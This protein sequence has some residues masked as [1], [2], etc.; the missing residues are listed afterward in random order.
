MGKSLQTVMLSR[1]LSAAHKASSPGSST[2]WPR[3]CRAEAASKDCWSETSWA[4]SSPA[5]SRERHSPLRPPRPSQTHCTG[6]HPS[7][8]WMTWLH[9]TISKCSLFK[10]TQS[11]LEHHSM[12]LS[13]GGNTLLWSAFSWLTAP[14]I[15][16]S[17]ELCL[18]VLPCSRC[19]TWQRCSWK[20][21]PPAARAAGSSRQ[22][23]SGRQSRS[24]T[25]ETHSWRGEVGADQS[26]P[27]KCTTPGNRGGRGERRERARWYLKVEKRKGMRGRRRERRF[28]VLKKQQLPP[29]PNWV[30]SSSASR[31]KRQGAQCT[32]CCHFWLVHQPHSRTTWFPV[33]QSIKFAVNQFQQSTNSKTIWW[34]LWTGSY[35]FP[36]S[37][38]LNSTVQ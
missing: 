24:G 28:S 13:G 10:H 29:N 37:T 18:R 23:G 27:T 15:I 21:T 7:D 8:T 6:K 5:A 19:I 1:C 22:A 9:S 2:G 38:L 12:F 36:I 32:H 33:F 4:Q 16:Y 25:S 35:W 30:W 3:C 31:P 26:T 14:P 20:A 11:V 34:T 17:F